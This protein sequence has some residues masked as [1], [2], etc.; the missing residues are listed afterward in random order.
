MEMNSIKLVLISIL[1]LAIYLSNQ[2][3]NIVPQKLMIIRISI[4]NPLILYR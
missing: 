1:F 4:I 3:H 2:S